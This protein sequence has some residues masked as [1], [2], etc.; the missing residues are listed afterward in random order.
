MQNMGK[1]YQGLLGTN[2]SCSESQVLSSLV[3]MQEVVSADTERD[4]LGAVGT[5]HLAAG[6]RPE[7][8]WMWCPILGRLAS[9]LIAEKLSKQSPSNGM[10]QAQS[11]FQQ[12]TQ[13]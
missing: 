10:L 3:L 13:M 5:G 11:L 7:T 12:K 8:W 9:A 2:K 1:E 4:G 6:W